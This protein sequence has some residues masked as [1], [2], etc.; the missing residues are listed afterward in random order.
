[1]ERIVIIGLSG[2]GKSTLAKKLSS[3]LDIRVYHLDRIFW[4]RDWKEKD[5]ETRIDILER[6]VPETQWIIEGTY[7][8]VSDCHL[9]MAD[10]IIFLDIFPLVCLQRLIKRHFEYCKRPRRDI[11][12]GCT[13]RLTLLRIAKVPTFPLN[14]RGIIKQKL[15]AYNSKH[16]I[17]L[18]S[19]NEVENFV[20]QIEQEAKAK[21][22]SSNSAKE[23]YLVIPGR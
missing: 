17:W 23:T 2:A 7:L 16:I 12:E 1:M 11:P 20:A 13:D 8:S 19:T 14:G 5:R 21:R 10:T 4:Q 3:I 18:H 9:S 22:V 15:R 6:L